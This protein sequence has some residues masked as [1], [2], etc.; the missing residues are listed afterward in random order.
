MIRKI[1]LISALGS[2][3]DES[4]LIKQAKDKHS[5]GVIILVATLS[6]PFFWLMVV[7]MMCLTCLGAGY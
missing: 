2:Y 5:V 1:M 4:E 3:E 7:G 6:S